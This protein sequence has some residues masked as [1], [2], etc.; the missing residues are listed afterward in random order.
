MKLFFVHKFAGIIDQEMLKNL[1]NRVIFRSVSCHLWA[2]SA[3]F[4]PRNLSGQKY[5][6]GACFELFGG[7]FGHLAPVVLSCKLTVDM[8]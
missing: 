1:H 3:I 5:F 6:F 2:K 4:W 7:K 8:P